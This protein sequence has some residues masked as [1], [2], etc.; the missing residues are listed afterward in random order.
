MSPE[1]RGGGRYDLYVQA[2]LEGEQSQSD[3]RT[4]EGIQEQ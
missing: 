1:L 4:S 3:E 2:P